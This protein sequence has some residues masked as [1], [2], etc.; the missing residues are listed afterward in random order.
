MGIEIPAIG[1]PR[2]LGL[3]LLAD[4]VR[5]EFHRAQIKVFYETLIREQIR[6]ARNNRVNV[7]HD[8]SRKLCQVVHLPLENIQGLC[9]RESHFVEQFCRR[10]QRP[11]FSKIEE[12]RLEWRTAVSLFPSIVGRDELLQV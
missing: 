9:R 2:L 10:L 5:I 8:V 11:Q 1:W 4:E 3:G 12:L 6:I 7:G